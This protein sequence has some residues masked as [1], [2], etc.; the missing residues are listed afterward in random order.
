[1]RAPPGRFLN[2]RFGRLEWLSLATALTWGAGL[3]I[4]ALI[5]PAYQSSSVSGSGAVTGGSATFVAVNG[6]GGLVVAG[7]PLAAVVVTGSALWRR[8]GRRSA[9][10]LA[11]IVTGLLACFNVLA[12]LSIGVF[13]LPVTLA[14]VVACS[15][16]AHKS[17]GD[18]TRSGAAT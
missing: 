13:A 5:V 18:I 16:H 6:W 11:W 17:H 12:I 4:A 2:S 7:A 9:G 8:A 15:T 14:L 1:M 3:V 10:V